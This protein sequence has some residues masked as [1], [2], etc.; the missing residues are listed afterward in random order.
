MTGLS[1]FQRSHTECICL[2]VC[3][4]ET[5]RMLWPGHD[6]DC[7]RTVRNRYADVKGQYKICIRGTGYH[8]GQLG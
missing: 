4:Q 7:S 6:L 8:Y 1:L 3:D 2:I 5:S